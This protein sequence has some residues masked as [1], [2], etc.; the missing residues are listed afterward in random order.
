M[1]M[2]DVA[3][4]LFKQ[5]QSRK[6]FHCEAATGILGAYTKTYQYAML[7]GFDLGYFSNEGEK[8]ECPGVETSAHI[9]DPQGV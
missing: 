7:L 9:K 8:H 6:K 4:Y 5:A 3:F 1:P 2:M